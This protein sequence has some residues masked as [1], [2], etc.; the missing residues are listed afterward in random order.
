ME[1]LNYF[2]KEVTAADVKPFLEVILPETDVLSVSNVIALEG[3]NITRTP[4]TSEFA[5]P[6]NK[7]YE[8][9]A[10][11]DDKI[12]VRDDNLVSD[13]VSIVP[14]KYISID[15]KFITEYTDLGFHKLIFGGGSK[16][17]SSLCE[18]GVS[19]VITNRIG[20]FINNMSLGQTLS[21]KSTLF[22][23]Y[24]VGG[25]STSNIGQGV[26]NTITNA[27]I[28]VNG[29]NP[30]TNT[31]VQTSLT[32]NNPVAALGGRDEPSVDEIR[33]MVRYN[34]SAQNR[35][36]TLKDYQIMISKMPGK[37]GV[38][39]RTSVM[40][41]SNKIDVATLGLDPDGKLS[42][43]S[44]S[45]LKTNIANYLSDIR[46]INDYVEITDGKIVNLGF[47]I[48]LLIEKEFP[49]TQIIN[50]SINAVT[51]YFDVNKW[52]MGENIYLGQLIE[53]VNNVGGVTNVV[54]IR[55]YNK[56]G[57]SYSIN[58]ISQPYVNEST[59]QIDLLGNAMLFGEVNGM[60][61]IKIPSKDILIRVK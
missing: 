31:N 46:M 10:L 23:Q 59:K 58:E 29:P 24:R 18:F 20:D 52:E 11:A 38:P 45:T 54:D 6:E 3:T 32:I 56:V 17:V 48:D 25:G 15:K 49:K 42:N 9:D 22:I 33:N 16:D 30:T 7:W 44:T 53:A 60:Y 13:N 39:F 4:I 50:D 27:E 26:I 19:E 21:P 1:Q 41:Y 35:A 47:E 36:V 37:F 14:G 43:T 28:F 51:E 34:M 61:E 5:N 57:G 12:F 40:E 2:Q 8:M 55:V